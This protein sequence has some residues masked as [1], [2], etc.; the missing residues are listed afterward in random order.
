MSQHAG[1]RA[2]LAN[3]FSIKFH[4][5]ATNLR[6]MRSDIHAIEQA[7]AVPRMPLKESVRVRCPEA[8][9]IVYL[10]HL[11]NGQRYFE[12]KI[13]KVDEVDIKPDM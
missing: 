13:G 10:R 5:G 11:Q 2:R 3:R 4:Y 8:D 6:G 7:P 1:L 9:E 12:R